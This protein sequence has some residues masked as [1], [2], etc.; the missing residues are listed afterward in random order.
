MGKIVNGTK[1]ITGEVRL[2]YLHVFDKYAATPGREEKY[3]VCILIPKK[4]TKTIALIQEAIANATD[5][6]QKTKWGGKVPKN[7]K[8]PLRDG[9]EEKDTDDNPEYAGMFFLNASSKRQPGLVD[10]HKQEIIDREELKSG[11]WGKVSINFFPF[12]ASGN[13]GIGVG[14]NN[15]MKTK[16][17]IALGGTPASAE[18]D[19]EGEF[20]DEDGL[21]D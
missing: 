5:L 21:L 11:D 1:V 12:A 4:D 15:I 6:G 13:N 16:D 18:D 2:S 20:E 9:D 3:S 14:I 17:G 7:L 8:M 19:F 10:S